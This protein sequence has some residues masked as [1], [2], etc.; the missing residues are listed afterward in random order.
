[1]L[2]DGALAFREFIVQEPLPLATIQDAVLEFLRNRDD[3]VLFGAQAVNAYVDQWRMTEDVD[4]LSA[5]AADLAEELRQFLAT[6]FH[7]AVRTREIGEGRGYRIFQIRK[8]KNRHL[9]DLRPV[10]KL[11]PSRL[12][13]GLQIVTPEELVASKVIAYRAR[14]G[15]PKSGSDWRD[16]ACLLLTFPELKREAGSVADRLHAA[17]ASPDVFEA[18]RELVAQ[19][20]VPEDEDSEFEN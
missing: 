9:V 16:L 17:G 2:G 10:T 11:P 5:R 18:W 15:Q 6:R 12:I 4:I 7:I 8:P 3:A 1:M 19:E 13:D 14:Q 20:I